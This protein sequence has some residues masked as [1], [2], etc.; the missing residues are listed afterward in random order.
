MSMHTIASNRIKAL[1][2]EISIVSQK[3]LLW[4]KSCL[5]DTLNPDKVNMFSVQDII[6]T[7]DICFHLY[8]TVIRQS[9][10][11]IKWRLFYICIL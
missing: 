7:L 11:H 8:F 5:T 2:G 3:D 9:Y 6:Y 10:K 1:K 4:L